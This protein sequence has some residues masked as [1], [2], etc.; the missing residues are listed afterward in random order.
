MKKIYSFKTINR[1][2][3]PALA[4]M[5]WLGLSTLSYA[6]FQSEG[7]ESYTAGNRVAAESQALGQT[8]WTTWDYDP[9]S[10]DDTWVSNTYANSGNNSMLTDLNSDCVLTFDRVLSSGTW[11][12]SFYTYVPTGSSGYFNLLSTFKVPI[13]GSN[14]AFEAYLNSTDWGNWSPAL[15]VIEDGDGNQT[16]IGSYFLFDQWQRWDFI[17]NLDSDV[18]EVFLDGTSLKS[19]QWTIG[20]EPL[21]LHAMNFWGSDDIANAYF[22]D[23]VLTGYPPKPFA[24][25]DATILKTETYTLQGD[26]TGVNVTN[27]DWSTSGTGTFSDETIWTPVYTPGTADTTTGFVTLT[28]TA[29]PTAPVSETSSD[30]M[31]LTFMDPP[32][33][34][35]DATVCETGTYTLSDASA[36]YY[37]TI[38]WTHN[39]DGS[40]NNDQIISPEYTPGTGDISTG[41]VTLTMSVVYQTPV[42]RTLTD[43][44]ILSFQASPT[45]SAGIDATICDTDTYTLSDATAENYFSVS[46]TTDGDGSFSS[47]SIENPVYTPGPTD[48]STGSVT[49]TLAAVAI[50]PCTGFVSDNMVLT[51]QASPTAYAGEDATICADAEYTLADAT[52]ENYSSVSWTT[53]GDGTFYSGTKQ[54]GVGVNLTYVPGEEDIAAGSV[55]LCLTAE[56][57]SPCTISDEDCMT[58]TIQ[59]LPTADAS[60]NATICNTDT[61]TLSDATAENYFSVSWTTNGDGSFS[62]TSIENPVYTPGSTDI[63]TGS[64]TLTLAAVAIDPCTGFVSDN[65][66]LTIQASPTAYAGE[67]A[68][69]CEDANY[70]LTDATA[71]NYSSVSWTT[72]GDGTFSGDGKGP[73][74]LHLTYSPGSGDIEVGSVEL[75]LTAEP[76][77]PCTTSAEDCMTLTI[78]LLPIAYPGENATICEDSDFTLSDAT[79]E[80]YSSVSWTTDGDGA[81]DVETNLNP[82]YTPGTDDIAAGSVELC[83]TAEPMSP[84]TTSDEECLTLTIQLLPVANAGADATTCEDADYTLT[85]ATAENYSSVSWASAGD[86]SFDVETNLNPTYSPGDDD[87]ESGSVELCLTAEPTDPCTSSDEDCMTLTI[88]LLPIADAGED[89][90]IC[91]DATYILSDA[92]AENYSSVSWTTDG[93]GT[94]SPSVKDPGLGLHPVYTPGIDDIAAG[95]VELCLTAEPVSPCTTSGEDC[96]TLT[97]QLL[98]VADAGDDVTICENQTTQ[99]DGDVSNEDSF[100]WSTVGDGT[101]DDTGSLTAVFTPGTG[102]I[103][104][105]SVVLCLTA[106]AIDP[107]TTEDEDC[108]TVYIQKLPIANA[109][110]DATIC[111]DDY[112][113]LSEV[114]VS[115]ENGFLWETDGDGTFVS[116]IKGPQLLNSKYYPGSGDIA[117]GSVELCLTAYATSPCTIDSTDCMTL[118]IQLLPTAFAGIDAT[119]CEDDTYTLSDATAEN[120][121]TVTW[122][123]NGDGTFDDDSDINPTYTP[124]PSDALQGSVTLTISAAAIDP[125]TVSADDEMTLFISTLAVVNAGPDA[126]ICDSGYTLINATASDYA[127]LLWVT[128][129]DGT[130]SNA[131][132]LNPYYT[133]GPNDLALHYVKLSL[134]ASP[135]NNPCISLVYDD[136]ELH[137]TQD[138]PDVYAGV[139][140]TI[141]EDATYTFADATASNYNALVWHTYGDGTFNNENILHSEYTPGEG[142]IIAGWVKI[143]LVGSPIS[144]CVFMAEDQMILSFQNNP[145]VIMPEYAKICED[146]NYIFTSEYYSKFSESVNVSNFSSLS[147]SG[148]DGT[149]VFPDTYCHPSAGSFLGTVGFTRFNLGS[150]DNSTGQS[151]GGYGKYLNFSTALV[152]GNTYNVYW[153]TGYATANASL[154]IDFNMDGTFQ[155][156][157]RLINS[158]LFATSGN[159]ASFTVPL[160]TPPGEKRLRIRVRSVSGSNDPCTNFTYGET[161]DYTVIIVGENGTIVPPTY[162]PGP[163]D[164]AN[165]TVDLCLTAQPVNPCVYAVTECMT[166]DIQLLPVADAGNDGTVCEDSDYI[167]S[168]A[169]A[170][171]YN[172]V[173]WNSDGDG[174]FSD[175]TTMN[176]TYVLGTNDKTDTSVELCLTAEPI[177]PCTVSDEDCMTLTIQPLPTAYAGADNTICED[178]TYT[179]TDATAT[180]YVSV[181]W[182]TDGDGSFDDVHT[183]ISTYTPG[184]SDISNGFVTLTLMALPTSPCTPTVSDEMTLS[185]QLKPVANAGSDGTVCENQ[186]AEPEGTVENEASFEWSTT[187]DGSFDNVNSLTPIYYNGTEDIANGTVDLCLTAEPIDPCTVEAED[188]LTLTIQK[189]PTVDIAVDSASVCYEDTYTFNNVTYT[190]KSAVLWYTVTGNGTFNDDTSESPIYNPSPIDWL[191]GCIKIYVLASPISPCAL[192]AQDSIKLCFQAPPEADAGG[193]ATICEDGSYELAGATADNYSS[194]SWL[195]GDGTFDVDTNLNPTYTPGEEDIEAGTVELCLTAEPID[196][197][198]VSDED[199]MTLTIQLLPIADAGEDAT[200]CED[201]TYTLSDASA[202]NYSSVSWTTDGNGTFNNENT[203][204]AIYTPGEEDIEAGSVELCMTAEPINP[205]TLSDEDCM[206]LTIQLLPIAEAGEDAT[207]CE[208]ATYTLSDASAENY[209]SVSWTTDGSGSFDNEHMINAT[210]SPSEND[211]TAGSV[212]L[213]M[214]AEP[215][216]PCTLSDEDCMILTF[217]L[218]PIANAGG[219]ATICEDGSYELAGATAE[220]Y[221]ALS[222]DGGDGT[223]DVE[224]NLNPTYT[225]GSADIAAGTVD[226]CLTAEPIDPCSTSDEDCMTLTIQLLPIADAGGD[227]TICEDANYTLSDASAENYTSVSW[228]TDGSGS[229]DDKNIIN[230]TYTPSENDISAGFVELCLTAEPESPC[231]LSDEDCTTLTFQLLPIADAGGDATICEDAGYTLIA[232]AENYSELEW[233]TS[234]TGTFDDNSI[235]DAAYT[236]STE[237]IEAG[238]VELCLTAEPISPCTLSDEDC[239]TLTIQLLPIADAGEDGTV[240]EDATYTLSDASAENYSSVTWTTDGNGTF[241]DPT[242]IGATYTPSISDVAYGSVELCLTAEPIS[243]C[244]LSDEDCMTLTIQLL[245][246]VDAGG[247]ATVCEDGSYELAD[248][249]AE[250]YSSVQWYG[251][252]GS[253][254][255]DTDI[256]P[257]YTPGTDDIADG[258]V[259]LC[260]YASPID[261]CTFVAFDCMTLTIQLLPIADAGDDATICED[262]SFELNG[263]TAENYSSLSWAGGDGTFDVDTDLNPTYTPGTADIAAGTVDLC[264]TA[265]PVDPCSTSDEDCMTLTIQLLP[266]A[267]AGADA[268]ICEDATHTLSDASAEN[269]SSVTWTTDGSGSFDDENVINATYS[270][271][272]D[273]ILA[274]SVELCL[275]AEPVSP[276]ILSDVDCMVLTFQLLPIAN[277]GD[278]ATICEDASYVLAGATAENYSSL[279]WA[280]GDGTFDVDTNLNPTYTPG[281]ADIAAGTVDL[282][283]TAEPIDPCSTSDEDCMTLTIIY[284]PVV[285]IG[286]DGSLCVSDPL[287]LSDATA[288]SYSSLLWTT[289]G[290]GTFTDAAELNP[291]YTPGTG[292]IAAG[293][294]EVCLTAQSISPCT[295]TDEDCV[296]VTFFPL[297]EAHAGAD[298]TICENKNYKL[299][300][301]ATETSYVEWTTSG[302][303]T[304][305]DE[306]LADATYTPGAN[307]KLNGFAELCLNAYPFAPCTI[308]GTDC[309]ILTIQRLPVANAG[310]D[311]TICEDGEYALSGSVEDACGQTLWSTFGDGTFDNNTLLNATYTPGV[312]DIEAGSVVLKLTAQQCNPCTAYTDDDVMTL[313]IQHF[314]SVSAD[315]DSVCE[316]GSI[317]LTNVTASDYSTVMWET[318][319]DGTFEDPTLL[320]AVYT[321]GSNDISTTSAVLAVTVEPM[322]PCTTNASDDM[323]LT[324]IW[325]PAVYAGDDVSILYDEPYTLEYSDAADYSTILW[326]TVG[327]GTFSDATVLHPIYTAGTNDIDNGSVILTLTANPADPCSEAA[328]DDIMLSIFHAPEVVITYPLD[329]ATLYFNPVTVTGTASDLDDDLAYVEVRVNGG[330]WM[331]ADGQANWQID[332]DLLSCNNTIE[333]RATDLE[334]FESD[335]VLVN[336]MMNIQVIPVTPGWSYISSFINPL[337]SDL[338]VMNQYNVPLNNLYIMVNSS[339]SIFSPPL[340]TNTIHN[341]DPYKGYKVKM[342]NIGTWTMHGDPVAVQSV[343]LPSGFSIFPV[344]TNYEVNISDV[345]TNPLQDVLIIFEMQS[346]NVYWPD[347]GIFTLTT[348]KPNYGY[349]GNFKRAVTVSYPEIICDPVGP[350]ANY[351]TVANDGPWPISRTANVHLVSIDIAAVSELNNVDYIGAFDTDGNC[352]GYANI[353][354]SEGNYLLT[355]YGDDQMTSSKDGA[356]ENEMI[357]FVAYDNFNQSK[358]VLTAT[359]D[360]SMPQHDGLF[361]TNGLSKILSFKASSTGIGEGDL[362]GM[363]NIYPNPARDEI[364]ITYPFN[365]STSHV[366]AVFTNAAGKIVMTKQLGSNLSRVDVSNLAPGVYI[367]TLQ[368]QESVVIKRLVIN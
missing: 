227:A 1:C 332:V 311:A 83:L 8:Y 15:T 308:I 9:G 136:I 253:F 92:T 75:C 291:T 286:F 223:F 20:G 219:D 29:N 360:N 204:N 165:E 262:G 348:L 82:T 52:A 359:F 326:T 117:A 30:E 58:L 116:E 41:F 233:E 91:E 251:G 322:D 24:G 318:E 309:M 174:S 239:M 160:G 328:S 197:C 252:D 247:D 321:P 329:D 205:C 53:E 98:P 216:S 303:G 115:Y 167:L 147:W 242:I 301:T 33:A 152:P 246:V 31:V 32:Y 123:T 208:D 231:T 263:A 70:T 207:I 182:T 108:M 305:N 62:S 36:E 224:T 22:D 50:D 122:T 221:S 54:P 144:P 298:A 49:L 300:G 236:P 161:E 71:E 154:W 271:S 206:T 195:G 364:T 131:M 240:C 211:I 287:V 230:A 323:T 259:D 68:S 340:N 61:Y 354:H 4:L 264:L 77:N 19:W 60:A 72:D 127:S 59:L 192:M 341:W 194:L 129:G 48:I 330:S 234:G 232:T 218:L 217:Q 255:D 213:C 2:L 90:T 304:F 201:A 237:D 245:P 57:E 112:Y 55:E 51:I 273:D 12:L 210:Y 176:P 124:G 172:S 191:Q 102:D 198:S 339:G 158:H 185:I 338:T 97:I 350:R 327:D 193:D 178:D 285:D 148:G 132:T 368:N 84:C 243:P 67:D 113:Y 256:N 229:F 142:D 279:S 283:L 258:S 334:S 171:N 5:L 159:N 16:D 249:T 358:E 181:S 355:L 310:D 187:G 241:D 28:L 313:T 155:T 351:E 353:D 265:E 289:S 76:I 333:A 316:T 337:N 17:I 366:N 11:T 267:D 56:P 281:T 183:I 278:D 212:E 280:G 203:I 111:E 226:L 95:S 261:P 235:E 13:S 345:M 276:C 6:Q 284:L 42:T 65:M 260:I 312:A 153:T 133:P 103:T 189:L 277:A 314:P 21:S 106:Q 349:L 306:T 266:I 135:A 126:D 215:V 344:L 128:F 138:H 7:F 10:S 141:C 125:C 320:N 290:D 214:T 81:F 104:T 346:N 225:P 299:N 367:I 188:C 343:N 268:T 297:P 173:E 180:H 307:D 46:W 352:V 150:I 170:T 66:V 149:F 272:V 35:A 120:Y 336:A 157:E 86:G 63:S 164:I 257:T 105:G 177:D 166:L 335:I 324:V 250:N 179:L 168:G 222:W 362:A 73:D 119:I 145:I 238:S 282:C 302:D 184:T 34:G 121:V 47:T 202:E 274:G 146:G 25:D 319:G 175:A 270:P 85:G 44:M 114:S 37:T 361:V 134:V 27:T 94:F 293:F 292:D 317:T 80:N 296:T 254:D 78:Q 69:V 248:A 244:T 64:V 342:N 23:F 200:I 100:I 137:I 209:N 107:C 38:N 96:M 151:S 130:F 295:G 356:A 199:C 347:G 140:A 156:S 143:K 118:T 3:I 162:T 40:F 14:W 79:A 163:N 139:D 190:D 275:T 89:A 87:I 93:D 110:P 26:V 45:A 109:G 228:T 220:N 269:Y 357:S 39:G 294:F 169:S 325:S 196:P 74:N 363:V 101:F 18:A 331:L 43:D 99:L 315:D 288:S 186:T 365:G 88:Q